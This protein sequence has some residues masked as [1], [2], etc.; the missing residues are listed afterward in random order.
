MVRLPVRQPPLVLGVQHQQRQRPVQGP[1]LRTERDARPVPPLRHSQQPMQAVDPRPDTPRPLARRRHRTAPRPPAVEP[2][3]EPLQDRLPPTRHRAHG[4]V[5]RDEARRIRGKGRV[6]QRFPH[7]LSRQQRVLPLE[8]P[9]PIDMHVRARTHRKQGQDGRI[10]VP[11]IQSGIPGPIPEQPGVQ[12]DA[13]RLPILRERL[14]PT[15]QHQFRVQFLPPRQVRG[16]PVLLRHRLQWQVGV[17]PRRAVPVP[18][19]RPQFPRHDPRT[20]AIEVARNLMLGVPV[21]APVRTG[22]EQR[23]PGPVQ[24][25]RPRHLLPRIGQVE[26]RR[27]VEDDAVQCPPSETVHVLGGA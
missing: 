7:F 5:I 10:P 14:P 3:L 25:G 26:M 20:E 19:L 12:I 22:D 23:A 24:Q 9:V 11:P 4:T 8:T 6:L 18:P 15:A 13:V 27:F 17:V 1:R 21:Q 2:P 16:V